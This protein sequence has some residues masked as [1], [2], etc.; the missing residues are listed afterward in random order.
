[1]VDIP[2]KT[3][4]NNTDLLIRIIDPSEDKK[5]IKTGSILQRP[6]SIMITFLS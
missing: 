6:N 5:T 1:M 3:A 4:K 2:S